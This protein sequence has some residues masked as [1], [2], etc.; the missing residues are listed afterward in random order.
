MVARVIIQPVTDVLQFIAIDCAFALQPLV[1]YHPRDSNGNIFVY[2]YIWECQ[3]WSVSGNHTA[4]GF[5]LD[6]LNS[7]KVI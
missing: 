3:I 5:G 1:R 2:H 6:S 4:F 7:V